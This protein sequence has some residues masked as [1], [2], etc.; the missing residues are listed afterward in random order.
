MLALEM[1]AFWLSGKWESG[2]VVVT[3]VVALVAGGSYAS[4]TIAAADSDTIIV[5][6]HGFKQTAPTG[7]PTVG[8]TP[9]FSQIQPLG[10]VALGARPNWGIGLDATNVTLTKTSVAG[11]GGAP[12][13]KLV[14]MRPHSHIE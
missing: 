2:T 6:P 5:F 8:F 9:D 10:S 1:A 3:P 13:A 14:L 7:N 12:A 11:S 4:W